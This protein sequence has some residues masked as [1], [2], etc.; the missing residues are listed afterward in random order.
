M[1]LFLLVCILCSLAIHPLIAQQNSYKTLYDHRFVLT[2][3]TCIYSKFIID[4]NSLNISHNNGLSILDSINSKLSSHSICINAAKALKGKQ[5]VVAYRVLQTEVFQT[6]SLVDDI[7]QLPYN[8]LLLGYDEIKSSSQSSN[9]NPGLDYNGAFTRGI[10]IGNNQNLVLNSNFNLQIA[11][12]VGDDIEILA[13]LTDENIPIQP[14]GNTQQLRDFDK[15][16]IQLKRKEHSLLAGDYELPKPEGYFVNYFKKLQGLTYSHAYDEERYQLK[17]K[18]SLGISRGKYSRNQLVSQEGNQGPYKLFGAENESFI[19]ILSGTEKVFLDGRQLERGID[20]DYVIDYNRADIQFTP[21]VLIKRESRIVIDFEYAVQNYLRTLITTSSSFEQGKAKFYFNSYSEQDSK[22]SSTLNDL[23]AAEREA[24]SQSGDDLEDLLVPSLDTVLLDQISDRV[25]YRRVDSVINNQSYEVLIFSNNIDS[26]LYTASFTDVGTGN[27]FY[28]QEQS[29]ANG[30]VFRWVAPDSQ[31]NAQGNFAA[32]K[33][34]VAPILQQSFAAGLEYQISPA[35]SAFTE[36]GLSNYD[37]NRFSSKNSSDNIGTAVLS[38]LAF[39]KKLNKK[40]RLSL[41]S[42]YEYINENYQS[43]K[44]FRNPEFIRDWSIRDLEQNDQHSIGAKAMVQH[45]TMGDLSYEFRHYERPDQYS[46]DKQKLNYALDNKNWKLNLSGD[47][48][49]SQSNELSN[50]FFKPKIALVKQ[51]KHFQTGVQFYREQNELR[52]RNSDTLRINSVLFDEY[53]AYIASQDTGFLTWKIAYKNRQE[54]SPSGPEFVPLLKAD[55]LSL[56]GTVKPSVAHQFSWNLSYRNFDVLHLQ[57]DL[58]LEDKETYLGR[59]NYQMNILKGGIRLNNS[60]EIGSGQEQKLN[61]TYQEV[62]PGEGN[63]QW[64]DRN[65]DNI[66]QLDEIEDVVFQDQANVL[67]ITTLSNEFIQT[68]N[69]V[70]NQF[71][72]I[73]PQRFLGKDKKWESFLGR[74]SSLSTININR[75][76]KEADGVSPWNPFQQIVEDSALVSINSTQRHTLYFNRLDPIYQLQAGWLNNDLKLVLS[77]GFESRKAQ[78]YYFEGKWNLNK[79]HSISFRTEQGSR[80]F[81]SEFFN[82]RDYDLEFYKLIPSYKFLWNNNF[83]ASLSATLSKT[84]NNAAL[85]GEVAENKEIT[86]SINWNNASKN[87][88][89]LSISL[90]DISYDGLANTP[91]ELAMLDGLKRGKNYIW[92]INFSQK[93]SSLVRLNLSYEGRKTGSNNTVHVGRAQISA[94]F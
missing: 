34:L 85:G 39:T 3:D 20:K 81:D 90:V 50:L 59:I 35:L 68:N 43:V 46:G 49:Q 67:R 13:A 82:N 17:N 83:R 65:E 27:G 38:K 2:N 45:S 66:I 47:F 29:N 57:N 92:N 80:L 36:V 26:T 6:K 14:E 87:A 51:W 16:F 12:K 42:Y 10:S 9:N 1:R 21:K 77:S 4:P 74:F 33:R 91:V 54:S 52:D 48:I 78:S 79:Q 55:E 58:D 11:G 18:F 41:E 23:S 94:L 8:E 31:G 60:Y 7:T 76:V 62:N 32:V 89:D 30:R 19:I 37:V 86:A 69:V 84:E 72:Q 75:K 24:L 93:I 15:I 53:D 56:Q 63:Y 5:I 73:E 70:L 71:L 64:F 88:L 61:Y 44:P 22:T 28:I 25:L 40:Y